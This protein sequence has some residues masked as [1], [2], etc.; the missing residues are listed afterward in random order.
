MSEK[1]KEKYLGGNSDEGKN[2][3]DEKG[4][5]T[6]ERGFGGEKYTVGNG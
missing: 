4:P 1:I 5:G 6:V 3:Y 2:R